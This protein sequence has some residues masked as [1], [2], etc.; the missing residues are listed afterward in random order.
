M[1]ISWLSISFVVTVFGLGAWIGGCSLSTELGGASISPSSISLR[2][3]ETTTVDGRRSGSQWSITGCDGVV[4]FDRDISSAIEGG[5]KDTFVVQALTP[6]HCVATYTTKNPDSIGSQ[7]QLDVTV[8]DPDAGAPADAHSDA[9]SDAPSDV[10]AQ[11][12]CSVPVAA[13]GTQNGR[14]IFAAYT[15]LDSNAGPQV[16]PVHTSTDFMG[17]V[18]FT[19]LGGSPGYTIDGRGNYVILSASPAT[20]MNVGF[21]SSA[22]AADGDLVTFTFQKR[23]YSDEDASVPPPTWTMTFRMR[24]DP[25]PANWKVDVYAFAQVP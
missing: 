19:F 4:S 25:D 10:P 22:N 15:D 1:R 11:P 5:I 21:S 24:S 7:A 8:V 13:I 2:V 17:D 9:P 20:L 18:L 23:V 16:C 6:G 14:T 12:I 3:G